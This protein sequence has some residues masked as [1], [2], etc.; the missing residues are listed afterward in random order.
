MI[1]KTVR[2]RP[3]RA[4]RIFGYTIAAAV[5]FALLYLV[6]VRPGWGVVP[7]LT[8][9]TRQVLVLFNLSLVAGIATNLAYVL[10][11]APRWKALWDLVANGISLAV[12]IKVWA[13]FPFAF[14]A[15]EWTLVTRTL[16]IIAMVGT[17]IAILAQAISMTGGTIRSVSG[18]TS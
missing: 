5:N 8:A 14:D 10:Y 15:Q 16:L 13:V 6:N 1:T 11:D 17:A 4:A 3:P 12:L 2:S 9:D 7:F 18:R